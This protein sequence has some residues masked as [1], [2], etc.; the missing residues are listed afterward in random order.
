MGTI[1]LWVLVT[2]SYI[3]MAATTNTLL[4]DED[5]C[6][7]IS[8]FILTLLFPVGLAIYAGIRIGNLLRDQ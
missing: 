7:E 5:W 1:I 4:K 3:L 8:R 6:D 2:L